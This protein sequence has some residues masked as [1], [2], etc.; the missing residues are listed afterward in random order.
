MSVHVVSPVRYRG[1]EARNDYQADIIQDG[2]VLLSMANVGIADNKGNSV[3][4]YCL[5]EVSN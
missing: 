5:I 3:V 2:Q 1:G 4:K